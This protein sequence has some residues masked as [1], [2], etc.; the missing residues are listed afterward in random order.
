MPCGRA[1][2]RGRPARAD[3][4]RPAARRRGRAV[5]RDRDRGGPR[6]R[7]GGGP[8]RQPG[9]V[10]AGDPPGPGQ[11]GGGDQHRRRRPGLS[12]DRPALQHQRRRGHRGDWRRACPPGPPAGTRRLPPRLDGGRASARRGR[13]PK[14]R[15]LR[16]LA[17]RASPRLRRRASAPGLPARRRP[18]AGERDGGRARRRPWRPARADGDRHHRRQ[19]LPQ[20][21][22]R[23]CPGLPARRR[24]PR[25]G[26]VELAASCA[27]PRPWPGSSPPSS[28]AAWPAGRAAGQEAAR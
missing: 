28:R 4:S 3:R 5:G 20:P 14:G 13:G 17:G 18:P 10:P 6:A 26:G 27:G 15:G 22:R 16:C 23:A 19:V 21:V 25:H 9:A 7:R 1:R 2:R 8:R 12:R 24:H 11:P